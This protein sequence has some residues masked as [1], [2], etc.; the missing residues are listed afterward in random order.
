M[1]EYARVHGYSTDLLHRVEKEDGSIAEQGVDELLH[2]KIANCILDHDPRD[3][4]LVLATGD[5]RAS[6]FGTGFKAQVERAL[7][8]DWAVEIW[9]WSPTL[10]RCYG[11]MAG[12]Y[13]KLTVHSL[14]PH[15]LSVTFLQP[16]TYYFVNKGAK[17]PHV[18]AERIVA[19]LK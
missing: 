1:W 9:S 6:E 18:V 8:H 15:Y 16:G 17:I 11:I 4:V 19:P 13:P 12:K 3:R 7:K 2:L 10:N 5:G 14:D